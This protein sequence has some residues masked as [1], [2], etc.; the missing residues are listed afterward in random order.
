MRPYLDPPR[1]LLVSTEPRHSITAAEVKFSDAMSSSERCCRAFSLWWCVVVVA[2]VVDGHIGVDRSGQDPVQPRADAAA[3]L[4][5]GEVAW[6]AG[7]L[8]LSSPPP[9]WR[10]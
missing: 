7:D 9:R 8:V 1:T 10:Q 3:L 2:V 5:G 6:Q 4:W